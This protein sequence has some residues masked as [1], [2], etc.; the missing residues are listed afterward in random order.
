MGLMVGH[1]QQEPSDLRSKEWLQ[2]LASI[3]GRNVHLPGAKGSMA[4]SEQD[5]PKGWMPVAHSMLCLAGWKTC[6]ILSLYFFFTSSGS[7]LLPKW[8]CSI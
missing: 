5:V 6:I 3:G 4:S 2:P 1:V 8:V 7:S